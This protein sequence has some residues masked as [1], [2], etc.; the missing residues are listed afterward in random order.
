MPRRCSICH[1]EHL[2]EINHALVEGTA[3]PMLVAKYR[4]SKDALSRHKANH[5]PAILVKA[6]EAQEVAH[7]DDLLEEV[8]S[9]QSRALAILNTAE[10]VGDLRTAL[11]AIREARGNLELLAKLVGQLDERPQIHLH[12]SPEWLELRT[13]IVG[14]LEGHQEA[15]EAVLNVLEAGTE[16]DGSRW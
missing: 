8:R 4:V 13:T 12:L 15:K 3:F 10:G 11:G 16:E 5:L 6:Q 7:A 2:E 1:H 14:A 9:L